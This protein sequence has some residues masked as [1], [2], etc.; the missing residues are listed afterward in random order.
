MAADSRDVDRAAAAVSVRALAPHDVDW[1]AET[2]GGGLSG[3]FQARRGELIDVLA[4]AGLVA[5]RG[6]QRV[7][8]LTHR[9]D[10]PGRIEISALLA[11]EQRTGVGSALVRALLPIARD[12]GVREIRVTTTNDN[13]TAL[14]FYQRHGFRLAELRAAAVDESRRT[15]KPSIP[16]T[17]EDDLPLRDELE[18][19]LE[20]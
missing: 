12:A 7:G 2:L 4:D 9:Q 16:E 1:A 5:E 17:G 6:G 14:A 20:I 19:S 3:R 10:G 15:L 13:L 11:V 18:L 8:L